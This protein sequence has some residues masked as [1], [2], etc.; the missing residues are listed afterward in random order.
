VQ[1]DGALDR[2]AR[3]PCQRSSRET[4]HPVQKALDVVAVSDQG[5]KLLEVVRLIFGGHNHKR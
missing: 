3:G 1:G 5:M 4:G 2:G